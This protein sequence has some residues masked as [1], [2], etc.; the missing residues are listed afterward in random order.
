M[1]VIGL[2]LPALLDNRVAALRLYICLTFNKLVVLV[3]PD[4]CFRATVESGNMSAALLLNLSQIEKEMLFFT[5]SMAIYI[6][7]FVTLSASDTPVTRNEPMFTVPLCAS[8]AYLC[9]L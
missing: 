5:T 8:T 3:L 4:M 7:S 1:G 9:L 6:S 2:T